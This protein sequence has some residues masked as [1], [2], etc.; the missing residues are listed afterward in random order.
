MYVIDQK[1][2]GCRML[3]SVDQYFTKQVEILNTCFGNVKH[4]NTQQSTL[5]QI[6]LVYEEAQELVDAFYMRSRK[7]I[8]DAIGDYITVYYGLPYVTSNY[9]PPKIVKPDFVPS[10]FEGV[11]DFN[12]LMDL[13]KR[14]E[15]SVDSLYSVVGLN[16][17]EF[18][19]ETELFEFCKTD[20]DDVHKTFCAVVLEISKLINIVDVY[21]V[22]HESNMSKFAKSHD[23]RNA[24]IEKYEALGIG[25]HIAFRDV[26]L[27]DDN[28]IG[29]LVVNSSNCTDINGKTYPKGKVLKCCN[30]QE[31]ESERLLECVHHGFDSYDTARLIGYEYLNIGDAEIVTFE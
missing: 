26:E 30:F 23:E 4:E 18:S 25:S 21:D 5:K 13:M 28:V 15:D 12:F 11:I 16:S 14:F 27:E 17:I 7:E 6:Q 1:A 22:I 9:Q 31:P 10:S 3:M 24:S 29:V 8:L 20:L 2:N 19:N